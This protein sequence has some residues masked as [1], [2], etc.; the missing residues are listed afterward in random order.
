MLTMSG[1][2]RTADT[3][4]EPYMNSKAL[5]IGGIVVVGAALAIGGAVTAS[6]GGDDNE[7]PIT[8]DALTRASAV[9]LE[10]LGEGRV[11]ET[12][13]GD[14]DSY[15]EV[16]VRLDDGREVDVQLD[17]QFNVVSAN[18]DTPDKNDND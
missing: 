4:K 13:V 8:G 12:E 16:E 5:A 18:P 9:A 6:T 2:A 3:Q 10:H 7:T 1:M 11:T 17:E 14:E 15:Y